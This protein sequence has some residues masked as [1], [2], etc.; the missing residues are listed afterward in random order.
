M[1]NVHVITDNVAC[2]P[3]D[4][5]EEHGITIVPTANI[6]YD[7]RA[8]IEGV[9]ITP[10]EAYE[11][12]KKDPDRFE[13]SALSPGALV[14]GYR[15][16]SAD[17]E[18]MLVLTL[19]SKLSA[20][21]NTASVAAEQFR[22]ESPQTTIRIV[23]SRTVSGAQG[24]VAMALA[25]AAAKGMDLDGLVNL[26]HEVRGKTGGLMLLDTLRYIYRTGRMTKNEALEAAKLNI[27]PLNVMS[28]EGTVELAEMVRKRSDGYVKVVEVIKKEADTDA[29]HFIV[30]HADAPQYAEALMKVLDREFNCLSMLVSDY[31]P[32]MGYGA[33]P[34]ALFVGF[35]PELEL[36]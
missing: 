27:K 24:L 2:I 7:G 30:S 1:A 29:L 23:D 9:D 22:R 11:L 3:R 16:L 26:A 20:F 31:S 32:V 28:Q 5:A 13:T 17:Y 35:Q 4:V 33:G 6:L 14:E 12:I 21:F 18:D 10:A 25:R 34:G 36:R 8:Y 15:R 19:S